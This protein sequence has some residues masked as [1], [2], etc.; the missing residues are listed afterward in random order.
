MSTQ[1]V[2]F[3]YEDY[4]AFPEDGKRHELIEGEHYITP[5]PLTKHQRI[6]SNL[7]RVI[8]PFVHERQLGSVFSAPT[9]VVFSAFDVVQPDFLFISST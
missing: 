5:A 6:I 2:K 1:S 7:H 3:T 9:D 8:T 4:L